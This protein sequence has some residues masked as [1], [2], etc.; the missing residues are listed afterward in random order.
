MY[1][2]C[3]FCQTALGPN[4]ELEHLPVGFRRSPGPALGHL[5]GVRPLE[6]DPV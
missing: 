1:A 4:Q 6:S 3:L 2:D 5:F